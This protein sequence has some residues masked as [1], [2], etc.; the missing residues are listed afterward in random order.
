ML[1]E[2]HNSRM[3]PIS[4]GVPISTQWGPQG[5][6]YPIQI[7]QYGLSH[8]SKYLIDHSLSVTVLENGDSEDARKWTLADHLATNVVNI[9][10]PTVKNRV[11]EFTAKGNFCSRFLAF[12]YSSVP[13]VKLSSDVIIWLKLKLSV[14][15]AASS[16]PLEID[17]PMVKWLIHVSCGKQFASTAVNCCAFPWLPFSLISIPTCFAL[18]TDSLSSVGVSLP[19]S[20]KSNNFVLS[21]DFKFTSNGSVTVVLETKGKQPQIYSIHYVCSQELIQVEGNDIFYGI[22]DRSQW[23]TLTRDLDLDFF[24]GLA[25]RGK[26]KKASKHSLQ[27][28]VSI[29]FHGHGYVDNITLSS[30]AHLAQF[31]HAADWLVRHQ[32][33]HGGWPINV[34]RTLANGRLE[35]PPGWYS[36]MA[37]GQAMSLLVRAYTRTNNPQYLDSALRATALFDIPSQQGGVLA[38][39]AGQYPWYEEYPT[40]PSCFVLNGFIYS[41][42]GLYD[43]QQ[44]VPDERG[45]DAS[46]LYSAGMKSLKAL[47]PLYDTGSGSIYD[48]RHF[49]L[50]VAPN[51]ARW[52]YHATH[53]N[54]LLLLA[55][56]DDDPILES[57]AARWTSYMKGKRAPHNWIHL[58][59]SYILCRWCTFADPLHFS[60]FCWVANRNSCLSVVHTW[61]WVPEIIKW[62]TIRLF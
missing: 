52:D 7:A 24:K 44:T 26:K 51:L 3:C 55:T 47:L 32:D 49:T 34:V 60:P 57:T 59:M 14:I 39:F 2:S 50:G 17:F 4:P 48:L 53:I 31:Y 22:G 35:L 12:Q 11:I 8:Y 37:Q 21:F 61:I 28:I 23:S 27:R 56:I 13:V 40:T 54:Q 15:Y 36:A 29:N 16:S 58:L 18:L 33:E 43:L 30:N 5:Y 38:T 6:F 20:I 25:L 42:I 1:P 41:L 10:L 9:W 62:V 45:A 19:V 46:R